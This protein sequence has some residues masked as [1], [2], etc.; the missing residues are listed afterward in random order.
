MD[1]RFAKAK[2]RSHLRWRGYP[3]WTGFF[4]SREEAARFRDRC[5]LV[6]HELD[7]RDG[8]HG[9]ARA[10]AKLNYDASEYAGEPLFEEV[11]M[12]PGALGS[13]ASF[14]D[15]KAVRDLVRK[16]TRAAAGAGGAPD[17]PDEAATGAADVDVLPISFSFNFLQADPAPS[18]GSDGPGGPRYEQFGDSLTFPLQEYKGD[19]FY[20]KLF[21][22]HVARRVRVGDNDPA[23]R[24]DVAAAVARTVAFVAGE[25]G[26]TDPEGVSASVDMQG[27]FKCNLSWRRAVRW[28]TAP[29]SRE[30]A[31]RFRDRCVLVCHELDRLEG[32]Q[33]GPREGSKLNY[34]ASEYDGEALFEE[35]RQGALG[36]TRSRSAHVVFE[37]VKKLVA[38][39]GGGAARA[40]AAAAGHEGAHAQSTS[41]RALL[42]AGSQGEAPA[43]A[44][45]A[46]AD[47]ELPAAADIDRGCELTIAIEAA[48]PN[49]AA[50][51]PPVLA[52][53]MDS[54]TIELEAVFEEMR[55]LVR[56]HS[57]SV[58]SSPAKKPRTAR[59]KAARPR[60]RQEAPVDAY[61]QACFKFEHGHGHCAASNAAARGDKPPRPRNAFL[62]FADERRQAIREEH[63]GLPSVKHQ[64]M[65][66]SEWNAMTGEQRR[67]W[68]DLATRLREEFFKAYPEYKYTCKRKRP[69]ESGASAAG[70]SA[71]PRRS[72][73][74]S[75]GSELDLEL[76]AELEAA[77]AAASSSS[78][79]PAPSRPRRA[80][81]AASFG[82]AHFDEFEDDDVDVDEVDG[83]EEGEGEG[84]PEWRPTPAPWPARL[85]SRATA[86]AAA[87]SPCPPRGRAPAPSAPAP[88]PAA[89]SAASLG[90]GPCPS[91][92]PRAG[93]A[94]ARPPAPS[95]PAPGPASASAASFGRGPALALGIPEEDQP[96]PPAKQPAAFLPPDLDERFT[97]QVQPPAFEQTAVEPRR[98]SPPVARAVGAMDT[99][100]FDVGV[101]QQQL[102]DATDPE[103]PSFEQLAMEEEAGPAA[104]AADHEGP[105]R[106]P[107]LFFEDQ[108]PPPP[109]ASAFVSG[110]AALPPPTLTPPAPAPSPVAPGPAAPGGAAAPAP[111][112]EPGAVLGWPP[113]A[114]L[115]WLHQKCLLS[116]PDA[117]RELQCLRRLALNGRALLMHPAEALRGRLLAKQRALYPG[118]GSDLS[119]QLEAVLFSLDHEHAQR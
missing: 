78:P 93:A 6:C 29:G 13:S 75:S 51:R 56:K 94:A 113:P 55:E 112:P 116:D 21:R 31:A 64:K 24:E 85:P 109:F 92:A 86:A 87:A 7:R 106:L 27:R 62:L 59:A 117:Q 70:P 19:S 118:A 58:G 25:T 14:T 79:P 54:K 28:F 84:D 22:G 44:P 15:F 77:D 43:E 95:A 114:A 5:I 83:E 104:A 68:A 35:V 40:V 37:D 110:F 47:A 10:P 98:A 99:W 12:G 57:G 52:E 72:S 1:S 63:P 66:A 71:R 26:A 38:K 73:A 46:G 82:F 81:A 50:A 4:H 42:E 91:G 97:F 11:R 33:L 89:A 108:P 69:R 20:K 39:H 30:E 107:P 17:D 96:T 9:A 76:A 60:P 101:D 16:H 49:E 103:Q 105:S 119:D 65:M 80:I 45:E 36:N 67:P 100:H 102:Q 3:C 8:L 111:W 2:F 61:V 53:E 74:S 18:F 23:W 48:D 41:V 115:A 90:R 32:A 88:G 34:D